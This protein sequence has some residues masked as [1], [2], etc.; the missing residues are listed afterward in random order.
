MGKPSERLALSIRRI[1]NR[2]Q[3]TQG[4]ETSKYLEEQKETSIPSVAAS[5]RGGA[6]TGIRPGVAEALRGYKAVP[7]RSVWKG[8]PERV[9]VP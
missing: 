7:S 2:M 3:P 8:V 6:Q 9:T 1:H 4:T 5:E